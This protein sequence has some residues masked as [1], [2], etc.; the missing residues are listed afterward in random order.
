LDLVV[1][2]VLEL[3]AN[4]ALDKTRLET[5]KTRSRRRSVIGIT[6][7][8]D[9]LKNS[10]LLLITHWQLAL[11]SQNIEGEATHATNRQR[12]AEKPNPYCDG[13]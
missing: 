7:T 9:T 3:R 13:K 11:F 1:V 5:K 12:D 8:W 4:D 2:L 6:A 10:L